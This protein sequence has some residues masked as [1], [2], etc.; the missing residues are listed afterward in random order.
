MRKQKEGKSSAL[1]S[2]RF[3]L[4]YGFALPFPQ[5][6]MLSAQTGYINSWL[7]STSTLVRVRT[8]RAHGIATWRHEY[9]NLQLYSAP[10]VWNPASA[11]RNRA[12]T[13]TLLT[14]GIL[15]FSYRLFGIC[16][17]L[18]LAMVPFTRS[19]GCTFRLNGRK[20]V[21]RYSA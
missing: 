10:S 14:T 8:W 16:S 11:R 1:C 18:S 9:F 12:N 21:I 6:I 3:V 15:I 20:R 19:A 13:F 5:L 17:R 2:K 4:V 7:T